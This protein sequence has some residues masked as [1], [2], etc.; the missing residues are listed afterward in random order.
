MKALFPRSSTTD[1]P[2]YTK[3]VLALLSS[4][5]LFLS[6]QDRIP[7]K[8]SHES[9][10]PANSGQ[11]WQ[12]LNIN[13]LWSSHRSDGEGNLSQG[14][15]DGLF[16]PQF[17]ANTVYEDNLVFGG[18]VYTG[19]FPEEGGTKT[20]FQPIRVN[21][22][23][24][25][26]NHG[27]VRGWI[28]GMGAAASPAD[29]NEP[30]V[31]IDRIRRDFMEM[32]DDELRK[33][34]SI[35]F[36]LDNPSEATQ[37]MME[38]VKNN[39]DKD[40]MEWPVHRGAPY[41]ERN[42]IPGFQAP[43]SFGEKFAADSLIS[44]HFDEPGI[45]VKG[46][47]NPAN[48]VLWTVYNGLNSERMLAFEGAEPIGLE[49]Q[50]TVWGYKRT[51]ALGSAYFTRYRLINKG[52]ID[53]GGGTR[54]SFF[55]DSLFVAQWADIE[56]GISTNDFL[57]CDSI[58]GLGYMYNAS[59]TDL[60]YKTFNLPP[61]A[62][63]YDILA[64]P[65]I[66]TP[67]D[68]A[69][70]D[71]NRVYGK[72]NLGMTSFSFF[73]AGSPFS[74]PPFADYDR[75]TGRWWHILRGYAPI[76]TM[77]DA[78][79]LCPAPPGFPRTKFPYSGD[80]VT[81]T[82]FIDGPYGG[83]DI[84]PSDRRVIASSGPFRMAPGD[85]QEGYV[86][87]I[88]GLGAGHLSSISV[89]KI[90]DRG[91][92][93]A[94]N[95]LMTSPQA[96]QRPDLR[97]TEL[98]GEILLDW[99]FDQ[100]AIQ[101]T[102]EPVAE[103]GGYMFEGY[104]VYQFPRPTAGIHEG[105]RIATY[106]LVNGI[107]IIYNY[108]YDLIFSP[109]P[110]T[111]I[112]LQHGTDSGIARFVR[113]TQDYLRDIPVLY[114][115]EEYYFGVTAYSHT[116]MPGYIGALESNPRIVK[117]RPRR[118]FGMEVV[119]AT[120][121]TIPVSHANGSSD[122]SVIV[123]VAD[124]LAVTGDAYEIQFHSSATWG[125][126]NST[127]GVWAIRDLNNQSG[128]K[129]YP[130]VDGFMPI[131][132]SPPNDFKAFETVSNANGPIDPSEIAVLS[133]NNNGFP[134]LVNSLYPNGTSRPHGT[135]QQSGSAGLTDTCG[136]IIH[137]GSTTTPKAD[138]YSYFTTRVSWDGVR[139]PHIMPYDFEIRFT[140][141]PDN[142]A[143]APDAYNGSPNV[144]MNVPFEIWNIGANT[145]DDQV[146][147]YRLFPYI[148]DKNANGTFDLSANDHSVSDGSNEPETD[149]IYWVIPLD[150]TPGESGYQSI[151][152]N[153]QAGV[154]GHL[155]LDPTVIE[156]E[157][158]RRVVLVAWNMGDTRSPLYPANLLQTMP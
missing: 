59:S 13:N 27:M 17:T 124:P 83:S 8:S 109:Q 3:A 63:W 95:L 20:T 62:A 73:S 84:V 134:I 1:S 9:S 52:G 127:K 75:G 61:P 114:N 16:F 32:S 113:V 144:M 151:V 14:G 136:W 94:F 145:V 141:Q 34:A 42:G 21:G 96:P 146:G 77:Y 143:L 18:I 49:V 111:H 86:G 31:R 81:R 149:W 130:I 155:F 89:M 116:T 58:L 120:G 92:Q 147:D 125:V 23:T 82:G 119:S 15:N 45:G 68:S 138:S 12:V 154:A 56:I 64:G 55:I 100:S 135:R 157:G 40:W 108:S 25:S 50:K 44:G 103:P 132:K 139:W 11:T 41:V 22:G 35:S 118:P 112:V 46:T 126:Y 10:V 43:P 110:G 79:V 97:A 24:Y 67:T 129:S 87:V 51:D 128:D 66:A 29:K 26:S 115:G 28:N 131:V 137:T 6:A 60:S 39:Y 105:T 101:E 148:L 38:H 104:N 142:W 98:D 121:D 106:D 153:I 80:P 69:I 93:T 91:C 88:A 90:Y 53:I 158:L 48:Q 54:G 156:D 65:M 117:V 71:L 30:A 152:S 123:T 70:F 57:G 133:V 85:T 72:S 47:D 74:D 2:P 19:G 5:T 99:S 150:K 102:E 122:G 37:A 140:Y 78:P 33:D 76:G 4:I 107:K 36:E 7:G